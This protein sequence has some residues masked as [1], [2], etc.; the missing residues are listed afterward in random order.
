MKTTEVRRRIREL[1][2]SGPSSAEVERTKAALRLRALCC[3]AGVP[4]ERLEASVREML[5]PAQ[6]PRLLA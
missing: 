6:T 5:T 4:N 1:I 3:F 2:A